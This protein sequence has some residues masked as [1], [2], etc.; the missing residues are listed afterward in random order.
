MLAGMYPLYRV[1]ILKIQVSRIPGQFAASE[2]A[3]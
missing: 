1:E 2:A 3:D